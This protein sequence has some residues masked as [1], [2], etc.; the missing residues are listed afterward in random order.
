M[1]RL[2]EVIRLHRQGSSCRNIARQLRMG[3]DTI[4]NYLD[5]VAKAGLLE[6]PADALPELDEL[7][8]AVHREVPARPG[9]PR[10]SSIESHR[11]RIKALRE[12]GA[13]P[14][15]I[16]DWLR[17]HEPEYTG[18]LSA[19]KRL[20]RQLDRQRGPA[21]TDVAIV[22]ETAP[23]HIAQV[24][25]GYAGKRYDPERGTMRKTWLFAMTLG[26]SRYTFADLVFDQKIETWLRLHVA[27][28]DFLQSVP[29]VIVPDNLKSAVVRAAFGVDDTPVLNRSYCEVA[30][31]YGF[32]IDPT[33]PRAPQKKGKVESTVK[34]VKRNFLATWD[35]VDIRED[36]RQLRRW[37]DEIANQRRHGTT[38]RRPREVFDEQERQA[39]LPLPSTRWEL[40]LWKKAKLHSDS[41]VQIDGGFYSAP[42]RFL[43]EEL[44]VRCTLHRIAIYRQDELLWTHARVA[45]GKRSTIDGHLPEYRR[46][47]RH[48]SKQYWIDR[49]RTIGIEV[50]RLAEEI[51]ASDDVL[52]QLRKV[53]AVVSHLETFPVHRARAAA[54]RALF[55]GSIDYRS[56]KNMLR[57]GLD[58]QPLPQNP[59]RAWSQGSRFARTPNG[60]TLEQEVTH[61]QQ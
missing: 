39:M 16:H 43:H 33:P 34:Y 44:W 57:R 22:V 23:G 13:G 51:F 12:K 20:C 19:V 30:R 31:H 28:F 10:V 29:R 17:L 35:T 9:Q 26:F 25:F 58:I 60:K 46:D 11:P 59:P 38:G 18:S 50:Q 14:T 55:Y 2:Q 49:A 56:I 42:W 36:R 1:H 5:A 52:L 48:R 4:R 37:L 8:T 61:A 6:G 27:A 32:Q 40:V 41:H 53:Q 24:D 7:R 54:R 47:L 45:R 21:A 15:A 3:R